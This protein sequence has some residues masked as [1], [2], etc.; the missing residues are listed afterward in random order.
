MK[1]LVSF[2]KNKEEMEIKVKLSEGKTYLHA[3]ANYL[4]RCI[5]NSIKDKT[6]YISGGNRFFEYFYLS[7]VIGEVMGRLVEPVNYIIRIDDEVFPSTYTIELIEFREDMTTSVD[8]IISFA[9]I[10][11]L[12]IEDGTANISHSTSRLAN[13]TVIE[14]PS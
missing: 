11:T 10:K 13:I 5:D 12:P 6:I 7:L 3:V 1:Y 4:A 2:R 14:N 8:I 9:D